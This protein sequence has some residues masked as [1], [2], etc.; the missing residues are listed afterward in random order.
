MASMEKHIS[1]LLCMHDCVIVPGLGGFVAN[2]KPAEVVEER[3]QFRPPV[4]EIGFNRSLSHNDGLLAKHISQ[5]EQISWNESIERIQA[6]VADLRTKINQG[7]RV[8]LQG[9][10]SFRKDAVG[11][12]QF[13]PKER[14]QL[15]PSSFGLYEFHYEPLP[16]VPSARRD[17]EPVRQLFQSRSPR[18]WVSIAAMFAGLFLFTSELKMPGHQ[19]IETGSLNPAGNRTEV[20]AAS[21]SSD[22]EDAKMEISAETV[23][24]KN[25]QPVETKENPGSENEQA[26]NNQPYHLIAASFRQEAPARHVL[27][28]LHGD[29]YA[30]A[31]LMRSDQGRYRISLLAFPEREKAVNR[32]FELR[33]QKRFENVWLLTK[34]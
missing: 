11:N 32:L 22:K 3:H 31:T 1:D 24:G 15:L 5:R 7:E 27:E 17:E 4:K 16:Y 14:N 19:Q 10:G 20:P 26:Q 21:T 29:G 33:K 6:F 18:Y 9:I 34:K 23:A 13:T 25:N 28:R 2:H 30:E 12:L 8:R